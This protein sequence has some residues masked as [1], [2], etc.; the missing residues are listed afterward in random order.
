MRLRRSPNP[1]PPLVFG[2][3]RKRGEAARLLPVAEAERAFRIEHQRREC[4]CYPDRPY[5][6]GPCTSGTP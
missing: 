1:A 3:E 2:L 6:S 5:P 4:G